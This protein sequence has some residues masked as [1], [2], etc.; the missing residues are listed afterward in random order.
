MPRH[1]FYKVNIIRFKWSLCNATYTTIKTE[2]HFYNIDRVK[3]IPM[4]LDR[5]MVFGLFCERVKVQTK[6]PSING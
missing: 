3:Q 2:Q 5:Q 4:Y 1:V 6:I